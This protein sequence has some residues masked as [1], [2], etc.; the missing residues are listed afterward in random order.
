MS[1]QSLGLQ[2]DESHEANG[3]TQGVSEKQDAIPAFMDG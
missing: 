3:V 1:N 2:L